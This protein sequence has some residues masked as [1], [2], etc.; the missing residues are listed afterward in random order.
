MKDKVKRL[1]NQVAKPD[2]EQAYIDLAVNTPVA[3]AAKF[4][5][6]QP[7]GGDGFLHINITPGISK[8]LEAVYH[9]QGIQP[10]DLRIAV[11]QD[12]RVRWHYTIPPAGD[13][14]ITFNFTI[15]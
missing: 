6:S 4:G 3:K 12:L 13:K 10:G 11:G 8:A 9:E 2:V 15:G 14:H 7:R 5:P 1:T